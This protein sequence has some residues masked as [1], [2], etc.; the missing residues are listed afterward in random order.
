MTSVSTEDL[1]QITIEKDT[2]PDL[3]VSIS[4]LFVPALRP[5]RQFQVDDGSNN[6]PW[7]PNVTSIGRPGLPSSADEGNPPRHNKGSKS[8]AAGIII[9]NLLQDI[10]SL[11]LLSRCVCLIK[12]YQLTELA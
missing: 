12:Q 11:T 10:C 9:A 7:D 4:C 3:Q 1:P 6:T 2:P 8:F 5:F